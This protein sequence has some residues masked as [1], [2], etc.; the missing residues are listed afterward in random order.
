MIPA[1]H[2]RNV[3]LPLPLSAAVTPGVD[4]PLVL[5]SR[6]GLGRACATLQRCR[7]DRELG[8][9]VEQ[10][11]DDAV[12]EFVGP[13][14]GPFKGKAAIASAYATSPPDDGI[15]LDGT[16]TTG[17]NE[18]VMRSWPLG[19]DEPSDLRPAIPG[20]DGD[21]PS[22][23]AV[24]QLVFAV[25]NTSWRTPKTQWIASRLPVASDPPR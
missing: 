22:A 4:R 24:L 9:F 20:R 23:E 14:V 3:T 15:Q 10:F 25:P 6:R 7:R 12:L 5:H 8:S 2:R 18:P 17:G 11:S 13:P 1:C 21:D 16:A 19:Q